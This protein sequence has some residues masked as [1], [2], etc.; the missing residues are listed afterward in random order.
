MNQHVLVRKPKLMITTANPNC[1][2][3]PVAFVNT[4]EVKVNRHIYRPNDETS[5]IAKKLTW[6]DKLFSH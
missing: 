4:S 5:I 6:L 1:K 2:Y 3:Q